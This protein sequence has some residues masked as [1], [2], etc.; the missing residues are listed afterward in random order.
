M[1]EFQLVLKSSQKITPNVLHLSFVRADGAEL[2]CKPGQFLTFLFPTPDGVKR[3]SYS[4]ATI[5]GKTTET[6]IAI[7]YII[8]GI[9]SEALFN[10][11][12]GDTVTA[13]GPFGR[14]VLKA[15]E[16]P[17]RYILAATG[18]GV[19]PYRAMLPE[20]V[21]KITADPNLNVLILLGVQY[22]ADLL[23]CSDFLECAAAHP[24]LE[25]RAYLSREASEL[26]AHEY[27]GY[28]QT[29]FAEL[30]LDPDHDIIYLCGNPNMI[31]AAFAHVSE[32]GF[33][34]KNVRREKYIS[35]N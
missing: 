12:V 9:A 33:I 27:K 8:G 25:F 13:T 14:L 31:D 32:L 4:I 15:E 21:D 20:L 19:A 24:Q 30:N 3:R 11:K 28:V 5:S 7:S 2:P 26:H 34:P 22:R 10:L 16:T 29:A 1:L 23:Y 17:A 6:E 18:T 35:S